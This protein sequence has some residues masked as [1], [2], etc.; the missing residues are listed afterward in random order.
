MRHK[1]ICRIRWR[2]MKQSASGYTIFPPWSQY[3]TFINWKCASECNNPSIQVCHIIISDFT[4]YF[5]MGKKITESKELQV[6]LP[7]IADTLQ[8][9]IWLPHHKFDYCFYH[10]LLCSPP[11][12]SWENWGRFQREPEDRVRDSKMKR[13]KW[14]QQPHI[15]MAEICRNILQAEE[16]FY[17]LRTTE[18]TTENNM[19]SHLLMLYFSLKL[20]KSS[21]K[22]P[23]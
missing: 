20:H 17:L 8:K 6:F 2:K 15:E 7:S 5:T 12:L 10:Q 14:K 19:L 13:K 22:I 11:P 23:A 21:K 1:A 16:S 4:D 18:N 3:T 9:I